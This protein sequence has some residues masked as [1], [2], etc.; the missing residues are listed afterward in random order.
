M[1]KGT[2]PPPKPPSKKP[3]QVTILCI[4]QTSEQESLGLHNLRCIRF[5][6]QGKTW[7]WPHTSSL[8]AEYPRQGP[9]SSKAELG[10]LGTLSG[11]WQQ[12]PQ[13]RAEQRMP[14]EHIPS[15]G[16]SQPRGHL[17]K[18]GGWGHFQLSQL[19]RCCCHLVGRGQ[20]YSQHPVLHR[21]VPN[22]QDLPSPKCQQC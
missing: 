18:S 9:G 12:Q 16:G 20:E 7:I 11:S 3:F 8:Q 10:H 19:G 15:C 1:C 5:L 17:V 14:P 22:N 4:K 2:P 21:I 6:S 13:G